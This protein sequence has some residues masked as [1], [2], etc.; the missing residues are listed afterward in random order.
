M[1]NYWDAS[2]IIA[3]LVGEP[4]AARYRRFKS[5]RVVTWWGTS[6]EC[7]SAIARRHREGAAAEIVAE[8]YRWLEAM[9][10]GWQE[11]QASESLHRTAIRL[12]K[13]HPLR[14]GDAL[15]LALPWLRA[16]SKPAQ[17]GS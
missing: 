9:R 11:V 7:A 10:E 17:R 3:L 8:S 16:I 15:H 5:E 13:Y 4:A 6:L 12:S 14:A 1:V 2:L